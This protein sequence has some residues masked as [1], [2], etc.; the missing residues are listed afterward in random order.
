V[1]TKRK[2]KDKEKNRRKKRKSLEEKKSKRLGARRGRD[3]GDSSILLKYAIIL[4]FT[5]ES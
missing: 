5:Y 2:Y 3:K 4:S 1:A